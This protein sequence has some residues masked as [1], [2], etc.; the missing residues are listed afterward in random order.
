MMHANIR[1]KCVSFLLA[2]VTN[3]YILYLL[4][5]KKYICFLN[6]VLNVILFTLLSVLICAAVFS[7]REWKNDLLFRT[8]AIGQ[9]VLFEIL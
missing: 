9:I 8:T 4:I 5:Y 6:C 1:Y 3:N 7:R 2:F